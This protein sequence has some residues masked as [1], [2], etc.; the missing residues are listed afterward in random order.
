M[1][2][3]IAVA[4]YAGVTLAA[5]ASI[6]NVN[7]YAGFVAGAR[8]ILAGESPYDP[9][10]WPTAWERLG[11]QKPD[12]A[13]Y[14]YP[15]W[16][17][18]L[19]LPLAPLPIVV[20]SLLFNAGTLALA[21]LATRS[22]AKQVNAPPV[23]SIV[24]ATASWPA[25]LVFLQGQWAYLLYALA[26]YTYLDLIR[27]RDARAGVWWASLV[28]L[29]PQ[30]FLLGSLALAGY[31]I[32][33]RR[34]RVAIAAAAL[35]IVAVVGSALI[36]PGWWT[37]WLGA[38]ASRRLVRSTQQPSLAGLAGDIAGEW[39]PVAWGALVVLLSF[40]ILWAARRAPERRGAIL[41]FGFLSLSVGAALYS[42]SYDHYLSIGCGVVALGL[43]G[44]TPSRRAITIATFA[45]FLPLAL[46]LWLTAFWRFHDT[47]SGLVPVLAIVLLAAAARAVART[48]SEPRRSNDPAYR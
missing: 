20:G 27:R 42:W 34:W 8:A 24:I 25:F 40:T 48:A 2:A 3:V 32:S 41:F 36:L 39:W 17:A 5:W 29:K 47:G 37:P 31:V 30:L 13:V 11:T 1:V 4:A 45:L 22:L 9:Q 21:V 14:G 33:A 19:F 46:G 28:L 18:L 6:Q 15:A 44:G 23:A 38:V 16:V 43:A 12:T 26:A 35:S 7:D 10:T